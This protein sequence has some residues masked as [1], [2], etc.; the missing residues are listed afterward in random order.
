[1]VKCKYV[2]VCGSE[3]GIKSLDGMPWGERGGR[4]RGGRGERGGEAVEGA[5]RGTRGSRGKGGQET[6]NS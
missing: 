6:G 2:Q 3:T 5:G 1:M 4:E